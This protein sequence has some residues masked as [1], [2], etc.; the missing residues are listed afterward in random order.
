[1]IVLGNTQSSSE[2]I[3]V[4]LNVTF[5]PILESAGHYKIVL[6]VCFLGK[7]LIPSPS[8]IRRCEQPPCRVYELLPMICRWQAFGTVEAKLQIT[9]K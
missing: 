8:S 5:V 4:E 9:G 1:M 3:E 6:P 7:I 2:A